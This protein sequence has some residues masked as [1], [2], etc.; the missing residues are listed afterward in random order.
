M[1]IAPCSAGLLAGGGVVLRECTE[2]GHP[3]AGVEST[4]DA[5]AFQPH[6]FPRMSNP[7]NDDELLARGWLVSLTSDPESVRQP[8]CDPP[9]YV[10][11]GD[12]AVEVT[13]ISE[14]DETSLH[15][16]K[17]VAEDVLAELGPPGNGSS[18]C[19]MWVYEPTRSFPRPERMKEQIRTALTP[20]TKPYS[21]P[22]GIEDCRLPC[23]LSL[24]LVHS[25][26]TNEE[27]SFKLQ[28]FPAMTGNHIREKLL[29]NV[30]RAV[31]KKI[32]KIRD[33]RSDFDTWWLVLVDRVFSTDSFTF[34]GTNEGKRLL[35]SM[36][37]IAQRLAITERSWPWSRIIVLAPPTPCCGYDLTDP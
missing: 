25:W 27:P 26:P 19:V 15:S 29:E 13:R 36:R 35:R 17:K 12:I 22:A 18:L 24:R 32:E 2:T 4:A 31:T 14:G 20:Y 28:G 37:C 33:R 8:A 16:L 10:L 3:L 7:E 30:E 9:D 21:M 6:D 5:T 11:N 23:G 1:P 34:D